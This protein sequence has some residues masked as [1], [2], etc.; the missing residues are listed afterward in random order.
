MSEWK[1][2]ITLESWITW[3]V[4]HGT[5]LTGPQTSVSFI[6]IICCLFSIVL[7][8]DSHNPPWIHFCW[9]PELWL[10]VNSIVLDDSFVPTPTSFLMVYCS[11]SPL[12]LN[13]FPLILAN[14]YKHGLCTHTYSISSIQPCPV[15]VSFDIVRKTSLSYCVADQW[16]KQSCSIFVPLT[17]PTPAPFPLPPSSSSRPDIGH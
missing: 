2:K 15:F 16:T 11:V 5:G 1:L 12:P 10:F 14:T 4:V 9:I 8:N 17:P 13:Y 7:V 6:I 3:S